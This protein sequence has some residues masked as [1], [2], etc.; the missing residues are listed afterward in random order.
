MIA[1][2]ILQPWA[3]LIV[4]GHKDIENRTWATKRRGDILI[5]AGKRWGR[6]QRDDLAGVREMFPHLQIP[7][8]FDLGGIVGAARIIDC[9][10]EHPSRWFN[11]PF[12]FVLDQQRKSPHFVPYKGQLG[13]FAV[14]RASLV[15]TM[16]AAP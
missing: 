12:G 3:W 4:N 16:D 2:S 8:E 5:H 9:V 11:G 10:S 13:F 7:D 6:E 1:L 14:P 15:V